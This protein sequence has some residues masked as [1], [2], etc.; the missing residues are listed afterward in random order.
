LRGLPGPL[1]PLA[2][3]SGQGVAGRD[4]PDQLDP[5]PTQAGQG[6]GRPVDP[7]QGEDVPGMFLERPPL[8]RVLALEALF[9]G[10]PAQERR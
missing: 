6:E 4:R 5:G 1:T 3:E 10:E 8:G 2:A 9:A 7:S